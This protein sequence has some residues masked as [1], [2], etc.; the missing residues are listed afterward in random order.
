MI[1]F[2]NFR[3]QGSHQS[4]TNLSEYT[5][6]SSFLNEIM[7][8]LIAALLILG[9]FDRRTIAFASALLFLFAVVT[10]S[11]VKRRR[12][13]RFVSQWFS[14]RRGRDWPLVSASVD[15]VSVVPQ[16]EP[17]RGY[18]VEIVG[19]LVTLTYFYRN[20][21]LQSGDYSRMFENEKDAQAWAASIKGRTVRVRIDPGDPSHSVLRDEDL[22]MDMPARH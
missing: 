16:T 1:S 2:A 3:I 18:A 17:I 21:E 19:Y 22:Q 13:W 11:T 4:R 12:V 20:P 10:A 15:V 6:I 9:G 7:T 5:E 14:Q 8:V